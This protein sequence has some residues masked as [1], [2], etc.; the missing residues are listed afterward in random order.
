MKYVGM[1]LCMW[2]LYRRSFREHLVSVLGCTAREAKEITGKAKL[3]QHSSPL[4]S[5]GSWL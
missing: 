1:P 3:R 4:S 2:L 5:P